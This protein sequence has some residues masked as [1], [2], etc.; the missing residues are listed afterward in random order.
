L[1]S[2]ENAKRLWR[3]KAPPNEQSLPGILVGGKWPGNFTMFEEAV[4][5]NELNQ[6]LRLDEEW[7]PELDE[8]PTRHAPVS[9]VVG[10][11]GALTPSKMTGQRPSF[12]PG[13]TTSMR[14]SVP[15]T[16][17]E[18]VDAGDV[19]PG[20]GF[21]GLKVTENDLVAL[22]MELG[23]DDHDAKDLAQGLGDTKPSAQA[24]SSKPLSVNKSKEKD[25]PSGVQ[26]QPLRTPHPTKP[27]ESGTEVAE[28][29]KKAENTS[30]S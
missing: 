3:R 1:A 9:E 7:D 22:A 14:K 15:G 8:D 12:A 4:E 18:E 2:D 5:Y 10:V 20:Y 11:P 24:S 16:K 17:D 27:E 19:L 23:L 25:R 30:D 21:Q 6:F 29:A 13:G 26:Q 28:V